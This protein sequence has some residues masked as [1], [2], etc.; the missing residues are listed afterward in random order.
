[1][2]D[3]R[4]VHY[5]SLVIVLGPH[6]PDESLHTMIIEITARRHRLHAEAKQRRLLG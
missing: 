4:S 1:M 6:G 5:A 2:H 3:R